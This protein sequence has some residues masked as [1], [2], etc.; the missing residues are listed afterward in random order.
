[1]STRHTLRGIVAQTMYE[2]DLNDQLNQT[3][4]NYV[5]ILKRNIDEFAPE[6]KDI[7]FAQNL[8]T[9]TLS[10]II[11]LDELI[12]K[13][14]PEWPIDKI[15][16]VDRNILRV[17]L[18]ELLFSDRSNVPPKV[19]IDEAIEIAKEFSGEI[20]GK[21]VNGVLGAIY[22]EM[23]EPQKDD[24]TKKEIKTESLV[25]VVLFSEKD[26][27]QYIGMVHDIFGRWTICKSKT[28]E[29]ETFPDAVSRIIKKEFGIDGAKMIE[30]IGQNEYIAH[31]PEKGKIKK[32]VN[33]F[34]ASSDFKEPK[35]E[36]GKGLDDAKWFKLS[37]IST[38][39]I[40]ED[41]RGILNTGILKIQN[42]GH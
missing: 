10:R 8:I 17:G 23:G 9:E 13:A 20:S 30:Q 5:S 27:E 35:V 41:M 7:T 14:A 6:T 37:E 21:F 38:L 29:N 19:A 18:C 15:N 25:G 16:V 22:K 34:V 32:T 28:L 12:Q 4:S 2:L 36:T 42:A 24:T 3:E 33:Y 1:M 39:E 40:Y 31:S 26:G 11:T